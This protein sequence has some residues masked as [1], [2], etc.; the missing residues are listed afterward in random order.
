[1]HQKRDYCGSKE[2]E[3]RAM[4]AYR[5]LPVIIHAKRMKDP[6]EVYTLEGAMHGKPG[7]YLVC[8]VEGEFYPVAKRIFEKTYERAKL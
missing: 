6:F 8:G 3:H 5:K 4:E 2:D 1:M 7:D